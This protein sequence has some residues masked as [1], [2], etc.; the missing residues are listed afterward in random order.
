[1]EEQHT[2]PQIEPTEEE[3]QGYVSKSVSKAAP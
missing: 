3:P 1:M 2:D